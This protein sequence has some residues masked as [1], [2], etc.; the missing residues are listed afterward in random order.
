MMAESRDGKRR[1]SVRVSAKIRPR[2]GTKSAA[3]GALSVGATGIGASVCADESQGTTVI[4][5]P[6]VIVIK[7]AYAGCLM[8]SSKVLLLDD[9]RASSVETD[10]LP[11]C[12]STAEG[13]RD[14]VFFPRWIVGVDRTDAHSQERGVTKH[15]RNPEARGRHAGL[16][17]SHDSAHHAAHHFGSGGASGIV[18][19]GPFEAIRLRRL[20]D[21]R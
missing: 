21:A 12:V 5:I 10:G 8:E 13:E 2:L 4:P 18:E 20:R 3:G 9:G 17:S 7:K 15:L 6:S 11:T 19:S 14:G 16:R 1:K